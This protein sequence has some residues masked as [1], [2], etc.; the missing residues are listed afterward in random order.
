MAYTIGMAEEVEQ[1]IRQPRFVWRDYLTP[2]VGLVIIIA[3]VIGIFSV[4]RGLT[5]RKTQDVVAE[6]SQ[7]EEQEVLLET[8]TNNLPSS[9]INLGAA[10][11]N[12]Q[13]PQATASPTPKPATTELPKTGFPGAA[14]ATISAIL[15]G[16][17]FKL[18]KFA[19]TLR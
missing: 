8:E 5:S 16:A 4:V 10:S 2:V 18:R 13:V 6:Q 1:P 3:I 7:I 15:A 17:G 19:K 11:T 12:S 9:E 14:L